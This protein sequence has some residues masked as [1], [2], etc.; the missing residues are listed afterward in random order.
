MHM[1]LLEWVVWIINIP[2]E[3][4]KGSVKTEPFFYGIIYAVVDGVLA[5]TF[6]LMAP[7]TM[8]N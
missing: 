8:N 2:L 1:V 3:I 5:C 4:G 6:T 7:K